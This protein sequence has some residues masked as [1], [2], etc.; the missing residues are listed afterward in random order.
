MWFV[1]LP[2]CLGNDVSGGT[3]VLVRGN[4][5][6]HEENDQPHRVHRDCQREQALLI[7]RKYNN[8]KKEENFT[9]L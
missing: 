9:D 5:E 7:G 2:A 4:R 1:A 6:R 3:E 8:V